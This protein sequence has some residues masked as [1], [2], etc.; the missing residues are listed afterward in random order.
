MRL[1]YDRTRTSRSTAERLTAR[2]R[3][4]VGVLA[5]ASPRTTVAE[6]GAGA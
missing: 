2:L 5:G 3:D 4:L 6:L 1:T